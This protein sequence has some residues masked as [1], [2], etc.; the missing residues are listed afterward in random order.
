M[1]TLISLLVIG[2]GIVSFVGG[3]MIV[4][5]AFK[6]SV[7]WGLASL[8]VPFVFI[9]FAAQHWETCKKGFKIWAIGFGVC[10]VAG[11]LGGIVAASMVSE[12]MENMSVEP[13]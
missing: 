9:V 5:E 13:M 2:G 1:T 10:V 12:Q 11:V 7:G 8:F 6:E 3:I 4:I